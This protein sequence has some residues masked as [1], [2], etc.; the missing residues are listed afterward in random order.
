MAK[1]AGNNHIKYR[2]AVF[3][4]WVFNSEYAIKDQPMNN[5][6][7]I[8]KRSFVNM[9]QTKALGQYQQRPRFTL[10]INAQPEQVAER[11][12]VER[13]QSAMHKSLLLENKRQTD[14]IPPAT[15]LVIAEAN[16]QAI[17]D[18]NPFMGIQ[19]GKQA[20]QIVPDTSEQLKQQ[21]QHKNGE[22][23]QLKLDLKE[24]STALRMLLYEQKNNLSI[25]KDALAQ[26][27]NQEILPCLNQLKRGNHDFKQ[28]ALLRI[29]ENN[30][31]NILSGDNKRLAQVFRQLTP[32]EI[33]VVTM[34]QQ[35]L[36]SKQIAATL[37]TSVQTINTHRKNIR[38]KLRLD[39]KAV[40]LR[41][42]LIGLSR[43]PS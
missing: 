32:K 30:A 31:Q 34:I 41:S 39:N 4:T 14:S 10:L 15:A 12:K 22:L 36:L 1:L 9:Q 27:I 25:A 19:L 43:C 29:L 26:E 35:G 6:P 40:N 11:R 20:G 18:A 23:E 5:A 7:I 38:K 8:N 37:S 33:Q 2:G 42:H 16:G 3:A 17:G 28:L 24:I 13:R 21:L